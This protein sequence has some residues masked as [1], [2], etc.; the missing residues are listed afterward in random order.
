[1]IYKASSN[2]PS[3]RHK[4]T[5]YSWGYYIGNYFTTSILNLAHN[6]RSTRSFINDG[7]WSSLLAQTVASDIVIIEMGHNDDGDPT[8]D[9]SDRATL[10][11]ISNNSVV[12]TLSNG[13]KETVYSF[14]W[15]LRKMIVDVRA[16]NAV[17]I[18][19]GMVPRDYWTGDTLQSD[20][21][22]ADYAKEVRF[23]FWF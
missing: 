18:L 8:T 9:T 4:L 23:W 13:T 21:P 14:G 3:P 19:S 20:W 2:P 1:M 10:P 15:Y 5:N 11:G 12:V 7:L 22:F 6:G 16:R 17:P